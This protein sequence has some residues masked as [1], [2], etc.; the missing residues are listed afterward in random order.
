L[1]RWEGIKKGARVDIETLEK[2]VPTESDRD[3]AFERGNKGV[4]RAALDYARRLDEPVI[5][6]VVWDGQE[7]RR[8][9]TGEAVALWIENGYEGSIIHIDTR[10]L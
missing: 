10:N 9:G 7:G 5:P 6:M 2:D 8:G 1:E 3:R 4:M